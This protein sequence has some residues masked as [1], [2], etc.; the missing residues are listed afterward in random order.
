MQVNASHSDLLVF[1]E[2]AFGQAPFIMVSLH[3]HIVP[4]STSIPF[5]TF[6]PII[7][8]TIGNRVSADVELQGLDLPEMGIPAYPD[9]VTVDSSGPLGASNSYSTALPRLSAAKES[10]Q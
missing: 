2:L 8:A 1:L 3:P 9:Y 4:P 5:T 10:A 7:G 6:P